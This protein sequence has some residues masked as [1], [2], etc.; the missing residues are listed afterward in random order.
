MHDAPK[1]FLNL[2]ED[3]NLKDKN[4]KIIH[5][6]EEV[7]KN[8]AEFQKQVLAEILIHNAHVEYLQRHSLNGHTDQP[9]PSLRLLLL[10]S[11]LSYSV[12]TTAYPSIP[13]TTSVEYATETDTLIPHRREVYGN[14]RIFDIS[15]RYST[16]MPA[17]ETNDGA[18]QFL[19]LPN[20]MKNDSITNNPEMK[21][22]THTG[23]HV[24]ALDHVFNHYFNAGFDVDTLDLDVLNG[25][26]LL[27]NVSRDKNI[28][29]EVMKSLH[30]PKG[31][32]R[33]L[34]RTLNLPGSPVQGDSHVFEYQH[35][36]DLP[37]QG[38]PQAPVPGRPGLQEANGGTAV[39]GGEGC[40]LERQVHGYFCLKGRERM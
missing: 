26:A 13:G 19:W 12:A 36:Q 6:I 1:K 15:H 27:V 21:L 40:E 10:L 32:C 16:T 8:S 38:L 33:V 28:T 23:T 39:V 5:F 14:G 11:C 3:Y 20:S 24:D 35:L 25:H 9:P 22:P 18:N 2:T 17:F 37:D 29:A 31:V 34:F 30:I 4:N 7:T